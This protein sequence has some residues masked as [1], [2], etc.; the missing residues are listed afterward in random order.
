[1]VG[2]VGVE[3]TTSEEIGFTDQ[4]VCRFATRPNLNGGESGIRTHAP[5]ERSGCLVGSSLKPLGYLSV[6]P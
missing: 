4:R 5:N 1:M 3:P 2:G 6:L